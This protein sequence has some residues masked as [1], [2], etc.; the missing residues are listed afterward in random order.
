MILLALLVDGMAGD[1]QIPLR[2]SMPAVVFAGRKPGEWCPY[3]EMWSS[4]LKTNEEKKSSTESQVEYTVKYFC[5][6]TTLWPTKLT[7]PLLRVQDAQ[8]PCW[9]C[10]V[11]VTR[12]EWVALAA[13]MVAW[14]SMEHRL[15][16]NWSC[17]AC[18]R[19]DHS[20]GGVPTLVHYF[21]GR[22]DAK[23]LRPEFPSAHPA[24]MVQDIYTHLAR[25]ACTGHF[26]IIIIVICV[27]EVHNYR[28]V[29]SVWCECV[30]MSF[31]DTFP[32]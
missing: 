3:C 18:T 13:K 28:T 24:G 21:R 8:L 1:G 19:S 10:R 11:I 32:S 12:F 22:S 15:P 4:C 25:S 26:S 9:T 17:A 5:S 20:T 23:P 16:L 2:K 7:Y 14:S 27:S 31:L 29:F 6:S 30:G